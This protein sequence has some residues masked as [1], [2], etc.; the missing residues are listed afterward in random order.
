MARRARIINRDMVMSNPPI[1]F[2]GN[3]RRRRRNTLQLVRINSRFLCSIMNVTQDSSSLY[4]NIRNF[5]LIAFRMI[6]SLLGQFRNHRHEVDF[7][8]LPLPSIRFLLSNVEVENCYRASMMR[9]FRHASQ[10][11]ASNSNFSSIYSRFLGDLPI[12]EGVFNIRFIAFGFFTLRELRDSYSSVRYRLFRISAF[13]AGD[14]GRTLDRIRT[15]DEDHCKSFSLQMGDLVNFLI[16]FL[17]FPIR[18]KEGKRFTRRFRSVNGNSFQIV[19]NRV[20]PIANTTTFPT[21]NDRNGHVSLRIRFLV[22]QSF[23]P[24]F[25]I[26]SR[27]RPNNITNLLRIRRVVI[28]LCKF[29]ARCFG[30]NA[31]FLTRVRA[32]LGSFHIIRSRRFS[33]FRMVKGEDGAN[34]T[35]LAIAMRGRFKLIACKRQ[36]FNSTFVK[37]QVVMVTSFSVFYFFRVHCSSFFTGLHAFIRVQGRGHRCLCQPS[38]LGSSTISFPYPS[39]LQS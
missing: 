13:I 17:H 25:R 11:H 24:F 33:N 4:A 36:R 10:D 2:S 23:L 9:T 28:K 16:T 26:T 19:P 3:Q 29:R 20:R 35:C 39:L 1:A 5:R 22:G 31:N 37:R 14:L 34:F 6:G 32:H 8:E 12:S 15:N 18:V 38:V 7:M 21:Y 30:R 27:T